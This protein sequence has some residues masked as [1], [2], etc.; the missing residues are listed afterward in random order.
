MYHSKNNYEVGDLWKIKDHMTKQYF[1]FLVLEV[2]IDIGIRVTRLD[3][4]KNMTIYNGS[5]Y[6]VV[7][8]KVS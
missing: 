6:D 7:A 5:R 2:D 4:D 1:L 3:T 8:K